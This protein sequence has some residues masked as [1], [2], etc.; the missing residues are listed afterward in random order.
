MPVPPSRQ[1]ADI[2]IMKPHMDLLS[3]R[4]ENEA[5]CMA[6]PGKQYAVYFTGTGDRS[7]EVD[8]SAVSGKMTQRWLHIHECQ[9]R[10]ETIIDGGGLHKLTAPRLSG[11]FSRVAGGTQWAVML[12]AV[13]E[14]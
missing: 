5:Y 3:S 12:K 13:E 1:M 8:L 2:F 6:E 11:S 14:K 9:W 10:E 7:V 4:E